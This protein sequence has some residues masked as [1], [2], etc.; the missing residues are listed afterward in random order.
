MNLSKVQSNESNLEILALFQKAYPKAKVKEENLVGVKKYHISFLTKYG[1]L[2]VF[3]DNDSY[4]SYFSLSGRFS[5]N[6]RYMNVKDN[7]VIRPNF[8]YFTGKVTIAA[9]N[10]FD[11]VY[12]VNQ[13]IESLSL[14]K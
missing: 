3:T 12:E 1:E 5:D 9:K 8:N 14:Q 10:R 13:F 6:T 2:Q 7:L 11:L 4:S